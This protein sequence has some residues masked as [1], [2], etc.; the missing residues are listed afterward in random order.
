MRPLPTGAA[1]LIFR[2]SRARVRRSLSKSVPN[3][4]NEWRGDF[5]GVTESLKLP[6]RKP[7]LAS[8]EGRNGRHEP[9][10][11]FEKVR[12]SFLK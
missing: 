3:V 4:T 8:I 6:T 1:K 5:E 7:S 10:V 2:E 12:S 9:F 11:Q